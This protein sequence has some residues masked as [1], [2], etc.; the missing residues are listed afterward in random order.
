[1]LKATKPEVVAISSLLLQKRYAYFIKR[2][3]DQQA[4]CVLKSDENDYYFAA[5]GD[6]KVLHIWSSVE[7]AEAFLANNKLLAKPVVVDFDILGQELYPILR[8][9]N[10]SL[11]VMPVNELVGYSI[12]L[13]LFSSDLKNYLEEWYGEE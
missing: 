2:I 11:S 7:Y 10:I 3:A 6:K 1:M 12:E 8:E 9:K 13:P 5:V 4:V